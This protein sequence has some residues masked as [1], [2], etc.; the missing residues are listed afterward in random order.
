MAQ[1]INVSDLRLIVARVDEEIKYSP[2]TMGYERLNRLGINTLTDVEYKDIFF[3]GL[4]KGGNTFAYNPNEEQKEGELGSLVQRELVTEIAKAFIPDLLTAYR[5]KVPL[6]GG[7][8]VDLAELTYTNERIEMVKKAFVSDI[9]K[10]VFLGVRNEKLHDGY[11]IYDGLLTNLKKYIAAGEVGVKLGNMVP[12]PEITDDMD[13]E[14]VYNIMFQWRLKWNDNF[15]ENL[16]LQNGGEGVQ[17]FLSKSIYDRFV[18]GYKA[19]YKHQD[20]T[21]VHKPGY[22]FIGWDGIEFMP[23][24]LMGKGSQMFVTVKDNLDF[25]LDTKDTDAGVKV[26][27]EPRDPNKI[28]FHIQSAIGTRIRYIEPSMFICNNHSNSLIKGL[29]VDYE[30]A[31]IHLSANNDEMGEVTA[32][33][34]TNDVKADTPVT[35][36]AT[37][38]GEYEF[39]AWADGAT[40]NPR[41]ILAP[42]RPIEYQAVFGAK[43]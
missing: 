42:G 7:M 16:D 34:D 37:A 19:A 6:G 29:G 17:W 31:T 38:K 41:T 11:H 9:V 40:V 30:N 2:L 8:S 33:V 3:K 15:Q 20:L 10:N 22:T 28:Y 24:T 25:G 26:T 1:A 18:E 5:D 35:L 32:D 27:E 43:A 36:T 21:G 13:N 23:N 14:T 39:K 12:M 4:I